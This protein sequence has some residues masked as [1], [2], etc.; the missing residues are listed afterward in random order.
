MSTP[1]AELERELRRLAFVEHRRLLGSLTPA[2]RA[3]LAMRL[4]P[5]GTPRTGL[6]G[7]APSATAERPGSQDSSDQRPATAFVARAPLSPHP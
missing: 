2:A 3:V 1:A 5:A 6:R 7:P 4:N